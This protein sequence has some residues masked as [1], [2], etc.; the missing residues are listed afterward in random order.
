MGKNRVGLKKFLYLTP[1][2]IQKTHDAYNWEGW[3]ILQGLLKKRVV[4]GVASEVNN[5]TVQ[6]IA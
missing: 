3:L 2:P 1:K 4:K 6:A 5:S